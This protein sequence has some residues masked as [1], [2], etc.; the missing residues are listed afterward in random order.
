MFLSHIAERVKISKHGFFLFSFLVNLLKTRSSCYVKM[1]AGVLF[2]QTS[3]DK[4]SH[5]AETR[6]LGRWLG[7]SEDQ[8]LRVLWPPERISLLSVTLDLP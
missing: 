7:S 8:V 1:L 5:W 6:H 4:I 3:H 2:P